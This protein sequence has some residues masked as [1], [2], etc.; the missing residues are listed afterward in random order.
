MKNNILAFSVNAENWG[1]PDSIGVVLL[2]NNNKVKN[3]FFTFKE[4]KGLYESNCVDYVE[5]LKKFSD[6]LNEHLEDSE[7]IIGCDFLK[8]VKTFTELHEYGLLKNINDEQLEPTDVSFM[9]KD[10]ESFFMYVTKNNLGI[11]STECD[12]DFTSLEFRAFC[13]AVVF[14]DLK[15]KIKK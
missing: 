4:E 2:N 3:W 15:E 9:L 14:K 7:L 10:D 5:M 11:P 8:S 12:R 1:K 6:V 13:S